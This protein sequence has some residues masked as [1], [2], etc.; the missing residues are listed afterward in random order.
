ML[1]MKEKKIACGRDG[2]EKTE[3]M[4]KE[5]IKQGI[6]NSAIQGIWTKTTSNEL[7]DL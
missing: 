2:Y 6:R 4:K 5:N 3:Y 7:Q 1:C